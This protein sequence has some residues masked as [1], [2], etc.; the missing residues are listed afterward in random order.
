MCWWAEEARKVVGGGFPFGFMRMLSSLNNHHQMDVARKGFWE[1]HT[2]KIRAVLFSFP[3]SC[4]TIT[5]MG[6][7]LT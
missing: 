2:L 1:T 7:C 4:S 5:L 3:V 6:K